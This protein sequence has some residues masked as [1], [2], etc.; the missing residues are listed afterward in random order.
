MIVPFN[1][2]RFSLTFQDGIT[3]VVIY[4]DNIEAAL[5]KLPNHVCYILEYLIRF[6]ARLQPLTREQSEHVMMRIMAALTHQVSHMERYVQHD[7]P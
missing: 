4:C 5:K 1:R 2:N 7:L 3:Y 6:V